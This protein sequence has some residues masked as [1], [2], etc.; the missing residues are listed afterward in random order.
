ML[1][2]LLILCL[3]FYIMDNAWSQWDVKCYYS[4]AT[5]A[6]YT[7]STECSYRVVSQMETG[8]DISM[9]S[10]CGEV[11]AAFWEQLEMLDGVKRSG[12]YSLGGA[13]ADSSEIGDV[14][15][16]LAAGDMLN[17]C[18]LELSEGAVGPLTLWDGSGACPVLIGNE[19]ADI[20]SVGDCFEYILPLPYENASMVCEV[21][22]ILKKDSHWLAPN[23]VFSE[24]SLT[25][26][27]KAVIMLCRPENYSGML[28][29]HL[30]SGEN[31][32]FEC[33]DG[34]QDDVCRQV[35]QI[36]TEL[37]FQASIQ[38]VEEMMAYMENAV[39]EVYGPQRQLAVTV[40]IVLTIYTMI[41]VLTQFFNRKRELGIACAC[42]F[43][44]RQL[45]FQQILQQGLLIAV[46]AAAAVGLRFMACGRLLRSGEF[47]ADV[48]ALS[49]GADTVPRIIFTGMIVFAIPAV[50]IAIVWSRTNTAELIR[51]GR[52]V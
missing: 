19:L 38:N 39:E 50:T 44:K 9:M 35:S 13:L 36:M 14:T 10:K 15:G 30:I 52:R 46:S 48:V 47:G 5:R 23:F 26:L 25:E 8:M 32:L 28:M 40:A 42:G 18:R 4:N 45:Y 16:I 31:F 11:Y 7:G 6:L 43:S 41:T 29:Y 21:A 34:T 51:S 24:K 12:V 49:H 20:W 22:G 3:A 33:A 2:Q 1:A 17:M 37:G 27:N